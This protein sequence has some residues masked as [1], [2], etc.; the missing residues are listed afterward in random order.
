MKDKK[1][2]ADFDD[3]FVFYDSDW[4]AYGT[5][6]YWASGRDRYRKRFEDL[7]QGVFVMVFFWDSKSRDFS[8]LKIFFVSLIIY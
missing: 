6:D 4:D 8:F 5:H 1:N 2:R 7:D 3:Y